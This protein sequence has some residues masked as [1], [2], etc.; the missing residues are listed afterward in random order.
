ML[1]LHVT[2]FS[3]LPATSRMAVAPPV[4][5]R[6]HVVRAASADLGLSVST[7]VTAL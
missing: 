6:V 5:V 2:V 7:C 1:K 3:E 4:S